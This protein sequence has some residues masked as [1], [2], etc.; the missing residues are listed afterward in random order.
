MIRR[1]GCSCIIVFML[2][3]VM[4]LGAIVTMAFAGRRAVEALIAGTDL[5]FNKLC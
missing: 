4:I 5:G 2:A 1:F 3:A